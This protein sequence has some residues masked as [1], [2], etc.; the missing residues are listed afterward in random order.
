M[1]VGTVSTP[2][3]SALAALLD[4]GPAITKAKMTLELV[5][6]A[7]PGRAQRVEMLAF[8]PIVDGATLHR[9][10]GVLTREQG[11]ARYPSEVR[12][13]DERMFDSAARGAF[14]FECRRHPTGKRP[15]VPVRG[16]R[17]RELVY[18]LR[19]SIGDGRHV[20][21]ALSQLPVLLLQAAEQFD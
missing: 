6:D 12:P 14:Q 15:N 4:R 16:E 20:V 10:F 18:L 9:Q 7:H 5:C 2:E 21:I 8:E 19:E 11:G 17:L 3:V 13:G 1:E